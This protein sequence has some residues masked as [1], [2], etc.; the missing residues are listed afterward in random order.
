MLEN[1]DRRGGAERIQFAGY[2]RD[3]SIEGTT[4][5]QVADAR[6]MHPIDTAIELLKA[7]DA[8]IVSF[9]M[10]ESDIATLMRQPWTMTASDGDLVRMNA[11]VPHPRAYGTFPRKIQRYVVERGVVDLAAAVRSMT[12]LPASVYRLQDRGT[13]RAGAV[14]DIAIFD[15]ARLSERA[16][17]AAPHQLSEGMVHVLVNGRFAIDGGRF[18][19]KELHGTVLTRQG[20]EGRG[21]AT[22]GKGR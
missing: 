19:E 8:G 18:N 1:L 10:L 14:A 5:Q 11:G 16:T 17:Y 12:S 2:A 22:L 7:G 15:L 9:N 3:R 21:V 4:L 20:G 13:L 6:G